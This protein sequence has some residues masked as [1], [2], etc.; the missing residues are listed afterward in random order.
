[1]T[2]AT[3]SNFAFRE[4]PYWR[5][6]SGKGTPSHHF[7]HPRGGTDK[8]MLTPPQEGFCHCFNSGS[9]VLVS[10]SPST[11]SVAPSSPGS[12]GTQPSGPSFLYKPNSR[13]SF[14]P[15]NSPLHGSRS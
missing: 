13:H 6:L 8:V 15:G 3:K 10:R 1:M 11:S 14:T 5:I 2:L 9:H 7:N 12:Q 4:A